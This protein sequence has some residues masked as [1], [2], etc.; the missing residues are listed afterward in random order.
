MSQCP[1]SGRQRSPLSQPTSLRVT[2]PPPSPPAATYQSPPRYAAAVRRARPGSGTRAYEPPT[3]MP[4]SLSPTPAQRVAHAPHGRSCSHSSTSVVRAAPWSARPPRP[5]PRPPCPSGRRR[6]HARPRPPAVG[7]PPQT[8][9][10]A[11]TATRAGGCGSSCWCTPPRCR[12]RT[13]PTGCPPP[14]HTTGHPRTHTGGRCGWWPFRR[15]GRGRPRPAAPPGWCP[16][17][18]RTGSRTQTIGR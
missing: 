16:C 6:R 12:P 7:R 9:P 5:P 17:C 8:A 1:D 14:R 11:R 4:L 15:T 3:P 18:Q 13:S 2:V 10:P